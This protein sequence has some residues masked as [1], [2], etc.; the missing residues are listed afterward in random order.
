V[1]WVNFV[2]LIVITGL[3]FG[4]T[5]AV[6]P[7]LDWQGYLFPLLGL[8]GDDPLL[9]SDVGVLVA[10]V[11]GILLPLITAVPTIRRQDRALDGDAI[12]VDA[13]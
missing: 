7:G 6:L 2:G 11:L 8:T 12:P 10:L 5:S 3:G 1:R 4:L 13:P 9:T